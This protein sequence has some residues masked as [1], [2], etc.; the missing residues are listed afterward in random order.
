[1]GAEKINVFANRDC[2]DVCARL[3]RSGGPRGQRGLTL[4]ES[5]ISLA[6]FSFVVASLSLLTVSSMRSNTN[7]KRFTM[8]SALAQ[9]KVEALRAGGYTAAAS[10]SSAENLNLDGTT[11]GTTVFNRTWNV[12]AATPLANT[13]TV[14]VTVAWADNQGSHQAVLKT[15]LVN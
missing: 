14:A 11:G 3:A 13:K 2:S 1:M 15:I 4:V 12:T 9:T 6:I 10:S 5:A 8:A 7:A